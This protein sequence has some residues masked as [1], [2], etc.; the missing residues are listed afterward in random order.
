MTGL[1][2]KSGKQLESGLAYALR[3]AQLALIGEQKTAHPFF[4]AAFTMIG[5]GGA[6]KTAI[7]QAGGTNR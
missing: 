2:E 7:A 4:W 5:D 3:D 6:E 1:F